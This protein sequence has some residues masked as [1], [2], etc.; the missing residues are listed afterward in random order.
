MTVKLNVPLFV[1]A[2]INNLYLYVRENT[3]SIS[4][5]RPVTHYLKETFLQYTSSF[6]SK[7]RKEKKHKYG[8]NKM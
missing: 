7:K 3:V 4:T 2:T 8:K 1:F 6:L 5:I